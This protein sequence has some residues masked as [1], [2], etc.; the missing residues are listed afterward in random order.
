MDDLHLS[1]DTVAM[2]QQVRPAIGIDAVRSDADPNTIV[3]TVSDVSH[4]ETAILVAVPADAP[5]LHRRLDDTPATI[6][7]VSEPDVDPTRAFA[8]TGKKRGLPG[9]TYE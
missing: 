9:V 3:D 4:H 6:V 7:D 5:T 8:T 2:Q 1:H